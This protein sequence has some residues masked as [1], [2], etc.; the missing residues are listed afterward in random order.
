[1]PNP[2]DVQRAVKVAIALANP[3]LTDKDWFQLKERFKLEENHLEG[4]KKLV[5]ICSDDPQLKEIFSCLT[6]N[7]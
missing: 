3:T 4:I 7:V 6:F 2:K 1:M 5:E